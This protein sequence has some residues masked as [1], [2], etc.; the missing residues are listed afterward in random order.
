MLVLVATENWRPAVDVVEV[1][2]ALVRKMC[3]TWWSMR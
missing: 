3:A 2:L 1:V